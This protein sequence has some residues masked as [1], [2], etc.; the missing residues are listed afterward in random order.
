[1]VGR[2]THSR[3]REVEDGKEKQQQALDQKSKERSC[4]IFVLLA[5]PSSAPSALLSDGQTDKLVLH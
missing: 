3:R 4:Y 2:G 5:M 1:M